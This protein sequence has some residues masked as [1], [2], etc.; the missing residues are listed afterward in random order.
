MFFFFSSDGFS[1]K[2]GKNLQLDYFIAFFRMWLKGRESLIT[3][4]Q[5]AMSCKNLH[6]IRFQSTLYIITNGLYQLEKPISD[7]KSFPWLGTPTFFL[8]MTHFFT[9]TFRIPLAIKIHQLTFLHRI[10]NYTR[11]LGVARTR[12]RNL[13]LNLTRNVV[14]N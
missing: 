2:R 12:I 13:A 10:K 6:L 5:G 7:F 3:T 9:R 8:L 1:S 14:I 11:F 4:V